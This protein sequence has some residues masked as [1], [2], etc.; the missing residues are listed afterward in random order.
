MFLV[1]Y[2]QVYVVQAITLREWAVGVRGLDVVSAANFRALWALVWFLVGVL[3]A[4]WAGRS[5]RA[6]RGRRRRGRRSVVAVLGPVLS[7]FGLDCA[8]LVMNYGQRRRRRSRPRRR[9]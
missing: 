2:V 6:C 1:G 7:V 9:C 5:P 3:L 4:G 8:W